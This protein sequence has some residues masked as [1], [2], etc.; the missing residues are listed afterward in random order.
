MTWRSVSA[1]PA[2]WT[3]SLNAGCHLVHGTI[4]DAI[5]SG[6]DASRS[7]IEQRCEGVRTRA[8]KVIMVAAR[9][10]AAGRQRTSKPDELRHRYTRI[11]QPTV[12][13]TIGRRTVV[14]PHG[15]DQAVLPVAGAESPNGGG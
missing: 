14:W 2:R 11:V 9:A 3:D 15:V 12:G 1:T 5:L 8:A 13:A 7:T 4:D 10:S 6:F